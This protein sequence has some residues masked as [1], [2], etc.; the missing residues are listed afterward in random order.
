MCKSLRPVND[1]F[2]KINSTLTGLLLPCKIS[3]L[4]TNSGSTGIKCNDFIP[5]FGKKKNKFNLI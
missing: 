4:G 5:F 2:N 3:I 1:E